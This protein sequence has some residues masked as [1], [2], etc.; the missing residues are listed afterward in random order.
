MIAIVEQIDRS[1]DHMATSHAEVYPLSVYISHCRIAVTR[2][3]TETAYMKKNVIFAH[4]F[5]AVCPS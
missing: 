3:L 1:T 4:G 5:R 2:Q